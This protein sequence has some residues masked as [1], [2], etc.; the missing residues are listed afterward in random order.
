MQPFYGTG[1]A[2][3]TPWGHGPA[4]YNPQYG[5]QHPQQQWNGQQGPPQPGYGPQYGGYYGQAP[6]TYQQSHD[7]NRGGYYGG[8][9]PSSPSTGVYEM[10]PP[11][12]VYQNQA[13]AP[14]VTGAKH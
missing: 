12:R 9:T 1:W 7:G 8:G 14:E 13:N 6:P 11:N 5:Q 3:R 4:Q 2:G 10:Q